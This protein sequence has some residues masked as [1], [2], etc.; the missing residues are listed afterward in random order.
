LTI[1]CALVAEYRGG[2]WPLA[3]FGLATT[4]LSALYIHTIAITAA[5]AKQG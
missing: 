5:S 2:W 3:L 4:V 1:L